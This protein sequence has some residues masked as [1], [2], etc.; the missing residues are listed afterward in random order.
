M[1][2]PSR[3]RVPVARLAAVAA[4]A[5][6]LYANTLAGGLV[7]DDVNAISENAVVRDG[8]V[9]AIFGTPSWWGEGRGQL[10]RPLTTLTFA[11]DYARFGLRPL[12][13]HV[14]NVAL[15]ALVSVLVLLVLAAAG[16]GP[17][18]AFAAALLFASHPVHTEAVANV[19]G[20]AELLAAAGFFLAWWCW[21]AADAARD[22]WRR[23]PWRAA[24]GV[25]YCLA[26]LAKENAIALPAVLLAA[27]LVGAP[28]PAP[29]P[30]RRRATYAALVTAAVAFV[31]LRHA[32]LGRTSPAPELLANPL[33]LMPAVPRLLTAVA[34]IGLYALR[35]VFP[36]RLSA[37]YSYDQIPAVTTPFDPRFLGGLAVL[38]GTGVLAWWARRREPALALGLLMLALTF[39]LVSNL[40]IP[41]GTIM[42]ERLLYLPSAGFCL[43]LAAVLARVVP[44]SRGAAAAVAVVV[45]LYGVRTVARNA[46]WRE[47]LTFFRTMVADAPR[48]ARSHA[49]LASALAEAGRLAEAREEFARALAIAPEEPV[50]LYNWGHAL[51]AE[52]RFDEAAAV[53]RRAIAAKPDFGEAF[54][55]LGN[56]ESARGDQQAALAAL[57]R[58]LELTPES[59]YLLM[60]IA[61]VEARAGRT[62]DARA[63]Y[64]RALARRPN[65]PEIL[66][67]YRAFLSAEERSGA[68]R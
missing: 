34:V 33:G 6:A 66:R 15:H 1:R 26:M 41:I 54:E 48:S 17:A 59:P 50:I 68:P 37:D 7:Y 51:T 39:A 52:G 35:L 40:V 3:D 8:D 5:I 38:V 46:V 31:V 21:L 55:N 65:D 13:Y 22:R 18:T 12:G 67:A 29:P 45:A 19:V 14:E 44:S 36:L 10:W 57:R 9:G 60:T 11:L 47:P 58:A 49:E 23:A 43:A 20:R 53:Y 25:V 4:V 61:N 2:A 30:R 62:A 32:A 28:P 16:V 24:A 42:G 63:T 64:E 27:D 56:V